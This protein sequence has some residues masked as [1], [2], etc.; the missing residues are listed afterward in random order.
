[1]SHSGTTNNVA[2]PSELA[3]LTPLL[4]RISEE[5]EDAEGAPKWKG[6]WVVGNSLE[7]LELNMMLKAILEGIQGVIG[8][9]NVQRRMDA[10]ILGVLQDIWSSLQDYV[11]KSALGM[12]SG[13]E[14]VR[15]GGGEGTIRCVVSVG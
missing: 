11:W 2:S 7:L 3:E 8:G 6:A 4:K 5:L 1:M 15:D 10:K 13:K 9:T 12:R 14:G